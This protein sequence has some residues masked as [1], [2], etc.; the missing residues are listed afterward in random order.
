MAPICLSQEWRLVYHPTRHVSPSSSFSQGGQDTCRTISGIRNLSYG[1]RLKNLDLETLELRRLVHDLVFIYK[2]GLFRLHSGPKKSLRSK[3]SLS[4]SRR[5][6]GLRGRRPRRR[7]GMG[8]G[9]RLF[10]LKW[11]I[12]AR[13]RSEW[14][15]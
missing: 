14:V 9:V 2:I 4:S 6:R 10:L 1:D 3:S 11:C 12:L 5:P 7:W 15:Y 8:R 13:F